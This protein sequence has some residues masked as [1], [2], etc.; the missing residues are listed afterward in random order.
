M[1]PGRVASDLQYISIERGFDDLDKT[2]VS[3]A[4]AADDCGLRELQGRLLKRQTVRTDVAIAGAGF[5]G[6][7]A[8]HE[9]NKA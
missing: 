8:A 9:L 1:S 5:T 3:G 6:L 2:V 7:S 4:Q